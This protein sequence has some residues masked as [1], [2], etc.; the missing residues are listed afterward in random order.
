VKRHWSPPSPDL[1][2]PYALHAARHPQIPWWWYLSV[3]LATLSLA[4]GATLAWPTH[5]PAWALL[6]SIALAGVM[7]LPI[8]LIQAVTNMQVGMNV[9]VSDLLV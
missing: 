3:F 7:V 2:D 8:G 9:L 4:L 6:I 1:T 5:L